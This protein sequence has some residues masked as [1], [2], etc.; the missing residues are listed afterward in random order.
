MRICIY[1]LYWERINVA[2]D[3]KIKT[4]VGATLSRLQSAMTAPE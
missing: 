4:V 2:R 3:D 1:K